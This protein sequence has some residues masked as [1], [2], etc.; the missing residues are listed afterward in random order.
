MNTPVRINPLVPLYVHPVD[1]PRAW[2]TATR[3][4]RQVTVVVNVHN[5]PGDGSDPCYDSVVADLHHGGVA[6][7]GYVDLNYG[8]RSQR[9]LTQD[10]D[11]W[12]RYGVG[13]IFFDRTPSG[14]ADLPGVTRAVHAVAASSA[15]ARVVLNPGTRPHDGYARLDCTICT[16]EGPWSGYVT[17]D[18]RPDWPQAAHLVYGVPPDHLAEAWRRLRRRVRCGLVTDLAAPQPYRGLPAWSTG[19]TGAG[20]GSHPAAHRL[21]LEGGAR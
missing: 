11:G 20:H 16:Y 19:T 17:H 15:T 13:G 8:D 18:E 10:I 7:L 4:G 2:S 9:C 21:A 3:L 5:G 12:R 14:A 1:D 6:T